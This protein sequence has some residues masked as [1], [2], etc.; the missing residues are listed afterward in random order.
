[1]TY[2]SHISLK[3][4]VQTL[5]TEIETLTERADT[6][7]LTQLEKLARVIAA[8]LKTIDALQDHARREAEEMAAQ[9]FTRFEDLPP[10]SPDERARMVRMLNAHF[11]VD[12]HDGA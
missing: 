3:S 2:F 5:L 1:M 12:D 8:Q 9:T 7:D 4:S 6:I 11:G 10:P